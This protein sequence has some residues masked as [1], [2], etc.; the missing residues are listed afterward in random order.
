MRFR[1]TCQQHH[2]DGRR[3]KDYDQEPDIALRP[4]F[5]CPAERTSVRSGMLI[6]R[7]QRCE[8]LAHGLPEIKDVH[9]EETDADLGEQDS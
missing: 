6:A 3:R 1:E 7:Q 2:D 4:V 9:D 5:D 8:S